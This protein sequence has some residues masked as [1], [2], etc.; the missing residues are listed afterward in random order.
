M[1]TCIY[2]YIIHTYRRYIHMYDIYAGT[3]IALGGSDRMV[4]VV[5][6]A[7]GELVSQVCC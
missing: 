1:F 2:V 5:D 3:L 7:S 4:H 6:A